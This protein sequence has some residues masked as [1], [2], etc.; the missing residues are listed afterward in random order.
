[1]CMGPLNVVG[2]ASEKALEALPTALEAECRNRR[3]Q[4]PR[5]LVA[6]LGG[7]TELAAGASPPFPG[8]LA[9]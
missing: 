7:H 2:L 9:A 5:L 1:M 8:L 4:R 6:R 3:L